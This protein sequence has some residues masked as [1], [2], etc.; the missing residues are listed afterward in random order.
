MF[1]LVADLR[2]CLGRH[3]ENLRCVLDCSGHGKCVE[4]ECNCD[5]G[6]EVGQLGIKSFLTND[7]DL[8]STSQRLFIGKLA[9][10]FEGIGVII[11]RTFWEIEPMIE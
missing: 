8:P 9:I 7:F 5:A 11:D 6:W 10:F 4:G 1:V 3:C 2:I